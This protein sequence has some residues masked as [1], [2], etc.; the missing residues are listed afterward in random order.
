V[1]YKIRRRE[2]QRIA[3]AVISKSAKYLIALCGAQRQNFYVDW[4]RKHHKHITIAAQCHRCLNQT[5]N[6]FPNENTVFMRVSFHNI[7]DVIAI[8]RFQ[9]ADL[10]IQQHSCFFS[11][12]HTMLNRQKETRQL[13]CLFPRISA[14]DFRPV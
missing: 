7:V 13:Q 9:K 10:C 11:L 12:Q 5:S 4:V 2:F 3:I 8:N 1:Q 6:H 14:K